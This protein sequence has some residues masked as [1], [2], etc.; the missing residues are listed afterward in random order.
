M[1]GRY[2]FRKKINFALAGTLDAAGYTVS[3]AF[4]RKKNFPASK[5]IL[6]VRLDHLGDAL[7][8]SALP[9]ILKQYFAASKISTLTSAAG[10]SIFENNPFVDES[11]SYD[12]G[13][14]LRKDGVSGKNTGFWDLVGELKKRRFD[15]AI[16]LRGD[17]RENFILWLSGIPHR[18]GY[19]ITG[20]G[21][22]LNHEMPYRFGVHESGHTLDILRGMG[23]P[24]DSLSPQ[25]YFSPEEEKTL[26]RSLSEKFSARGLTLKDIRVGLQTE[27]GSSSKNWP[28]EH[29]QNFLKRFACDFPSEKIVLLGSRNPDDFS[30]ASVVDL[31]GKTGL[32]E[33]FFLI[34][35]LKAFV[36]PDSGPAHAAAAMGVPTLFL[37]S[38]T[39]VFEEWKSLAPNAFF[40]RHPVPCAPCHKTECDVPGHPCMSGIEPGQVLDWLRPRL[41]ES[42]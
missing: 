6:L 5:N 28:A 20:G 13:W 12:A 19:G 3:S 17:L 41:G 10:K 37:Y 15:A 7:S 18:V 16:G 35:R 36:G 26:E 11:L 9:K 39:N 38:G 34:R 30:S 27:A 32:R 40:L 29:A 24:A 42:S 25:I 1:L 33:L 22:F 23:I 2:V 14:F 31:R 4:G 21:F 8:A